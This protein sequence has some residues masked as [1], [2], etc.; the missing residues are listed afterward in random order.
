MGTP[1]TLAA[2]GQAF[3]EP[4][5]A[6]TRNAL[7]ITL[8]FVPMF[9]ASLVPYIVVVAF[10]TSIMLI[11]WLVTLLILPAAITLWERERHKCAEGPAGS[12][13]AATRRY[14]SDG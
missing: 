5:R 12:K 11:S 7:I 9:F 13:A 1:A 6:L 4:A 14:A 8:G 3:E 10:L 2:L